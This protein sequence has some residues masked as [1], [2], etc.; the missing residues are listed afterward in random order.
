M[1]LNPQL[2]LD[3]KYEN[4]SYVKYVGEEKTKQRKLIS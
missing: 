2:S 4:H 1:L 3:P